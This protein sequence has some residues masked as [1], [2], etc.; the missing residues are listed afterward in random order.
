M[1]KDE[2]L[3]LALE[4]L[5]NH[6]GNYKLDAAG[7]VRHEKAITAIK[8]ALAQPAMRKTTREEKISNPEVYEVPWTSEDMAHRPGGLAQS[9]P[10]AEQEPVARIG[11]I[12]EDHFADVCR[13]AGGNSNTQL[14]TS[15]PKREWVE[16]T[17]TDREQLRDEFEDWSYS[18][19]LIDAVADK[20]KEKNA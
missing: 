4:A 6:C 8:E 13:K 19:I 12:D 10:T 2:A 7:V 16:L 3:K 11:M 17:M 5:E 9:A 14:Y 20:L 1:N 18:A 15:P